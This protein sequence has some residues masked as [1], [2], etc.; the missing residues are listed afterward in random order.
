[1]KND[2]KGTQNLPMRPT[3]VHKEL[4]RELR[5]LDIRQIDVARAT[6]LDPAGVSL[7]LSG[8]L[9]WRLREVYIIMDMIGQPLEKI[10]FYF[11]ESVVL[12]RN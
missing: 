12:G 9:P 3:P 2:G 1:M 11:P 5:T 8:K 4:S 7:R 10:P 6:L